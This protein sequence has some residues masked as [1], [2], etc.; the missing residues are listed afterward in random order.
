MVFHIRTILFYTIFRQR[1][2]GPRISKRFALVLAFACAFTMFAGAAFT[3]QSDIAVD[4]DV[5]DTMSSLGVIE[6]YLDGSFRPDD[7]VTRAEMAKMIY[8]IRTGRSDASAYNDDATTFTDIGDHWARG[9]INFCYANGIIAGIGNN[10]FAP[11]DNVTG[12]EL[13]K[14]LL[15]CM[16]Y[17]ADKSNLTGTSWVQNTN[18]LA[19]QNGL[20]VDV[21]SSVSAAMP[22]QFAAQLMYNALKADTVTWSSDRNAYERVSTVTYQMVSNNNGGYNLVP[23]TDYETLGQKCMGLE[24]REILLTSVEKENGRDTYKLNGNAFTRVATDYTDLIGQYVNVLIK[25]GETD[26]VYGVYA[27]EDSSV[28]ASGVV[29]Q[30]ELDGTNTD[31]VKLDGTS[32]DLDD[33]L[34]DTKVYVTNKDTSVNVPLNTIVENPSSERDDAFSIKLIDIDNDGDVNHA[35][36]TPA[37]VAQVSYDNGTTLRINSSTVNTSGDYEID[38]AY[39]YDDHNIADDIE[40]DDWVVITAADFTVDEKAVI[41]KA[42]VVS[43]TVAARHTDTTG[44]NEVR[45]DGIWYKTADVVTD[46]TTNIGNDVDLVVYGNM[47]FSVEGSVGALDVAVITGVGNYNRMDDATEVRMMFQDG[48]EEVVNVER[49]ITATGTTGDDDG[50]WFTD[51]D[52]ATTG[53]SLG[54]SLEKGMMVAYD[55][56]DDKYSVVEVPENAKVVDTDYDGVQLKSGDYVY[57]DDD[58]TVTA[59]GKTYDVDDGALVVI[60]NGVGDFIRMTG[61]DLLSRNGITF[62]A[63]SDETKGE[64]GYIVADEDGN[65][66]A[67]YG[68]TNSSITTGAEQYGY[69]ADSALEWVDGERKLVID[70]ITADG[71][72]EGVVTDKN[73][74]G[75]FTTGQVITYTM[76][77][78]VMVI[79]EKNDLVYGAV[80]ENWDTRVRL[81]DGDRYSITDDTV[82][83]AIRDAGTDDADFE[84]NSLMNAQD[85][86]HFNVIYAVD[87]NEITVIF[88]DVDNDEADS[89]GDLYDFGRSDSN[90]NATGAA[91]QPDGKYSYPQA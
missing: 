29:G 55:I 86:D 75:N 12:T 90:L 70:V 79:S 14:M 23:V 58:A 73:A 43:G 85:K 56:D 84:S 17:Q 65:I 10:R 78:D 16:G 3:D 7:T 41:T 15:I 71:K 44:T 32:Y 35:V 19:T 22:R 18:A 13:A 37:Y 69:I 8:I 33:T 1:L 47:Y 72:Q 60:Q 11:E 67:M 74:I 5:V 88:V 40:R 53:G 28:V 34:T 36:I 4:A 9:Y 39:G 38:T 31:K 89:T 20:Y 64:I 52:A 48:S 91:S 82:I 81:Y 27:D 87:Q 80:Q 50:E 62:V 54:S 77:G 63:G 57:D 83:I 46:R 6:G 25:D 42:D 59:N 24:T 51:D 68:K 49:L 61:A 76:D 26:Q 2:R 21:T 45:V 66:V 30:L